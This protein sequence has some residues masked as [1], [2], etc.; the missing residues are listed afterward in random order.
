MNVDQVGVLTSCNGTS[1]LASLKFSDISHLNWRFSYITSREN[2]MRW[3]KEEFIAMK[4]V[5]TSLFALFFVFSL[6]VPAVHAEEGVPESDIQEDVAVQETESQPSAQVTAREKTEEN[7]MLLH[8]L[9]NEDKG[10]ASYIPT[11]TVSLYT[12][13]GDLIS[14]VEAGEQNYNEEEGRYELYFNFTEY[15]K[16]EKY[17]IL[18]NS[19]DDIVTGLA[20]QV[21]SLD[22]FAYGEAVLKKPNDYY[23]F[24]VD[25][26]EYYEDIDETK[27]VSALIPSKRFPMEAVLQT[28]KSKVG[29]YIVNEQ[30]QPLKNVPVQVRLEGGKGTLNLKTNDKGLAV[31]DSSKIPNT[32][33]VSVENKKAVGSNGYSAVVERPLTAL[34]SSQ[35]GILT[36]RLAFEDDISQEENAGFLNVTVST[37]GTS[38]L[39]SHWQNVDLNLTDT[40]GVTRTYSINA[41]GQKIYGL[42][43]GQYKVSVDSAYANAKLSVDSLTIKNGKGELALTLTP[44]YTLEVSKDGKAYDFSFVGVSGFESRNFTGNKSHVFAV[45]PGESYVIKDNVTGQLTT[46]AIDSNSLVTKVVLG[47]G[48]VFGGTIT[49]PHTGDVLMYLIV[50]ALVSTVLAFGFF[51]LYRRN[52]KILKS[53]TSLV[54]LLLVVTLMAQFFPPLADRAYADMGSGDAVDQ[55][56]GKFT[57]AGVIQ[58]SPTISVL[59]VGI[60]P[61][62]T[63]HEQE[64]VHLGKPID[65]KI[66]AGVAVEDLE[67]LLPIMPSDR[68]YYTDIIRKEDGAYVR[69]SPYKKDKDGYKVLR[70][71]SNSS[72]TNM[73]DIYKFTG[74][75]YKHMFYVAPNPESESILKRSN[76]TLLVFEDGKVKRLHGGT[77]GFDHGVSK[78]ASGFNLQDMILSTNGEAKTAISNEGLAYYLGSLIT[79]FGNIKVTL[80]VDDAFKGFVRDSLKYLSLSPEGRQLWKGEN[81]RSNQNIGDIMDRLFARNLSE[82]YLLNTLKKIS[83]NNKIV[84]TGVL[85]LITLEYLKNSNFWSEEFFTMYFNHLMKVGHEDYARKLRQ[86]HEEGDIQDLVF[87]AQV[88]PAFY[89][90]G[91]TSHYAFMPM[92][93]ATAW[94]RKGRSLENDDFNSI[95][96]AHEA[97]IMYKRN[98]DGTLERGGKL[99]SNVAKLYPTSTFVYNMRPGLAAALKP[100]SSNVPIPTGTDPKTGELL[101]TIDL[102]NSSE[103]DLGDNPFLGWGYTNL[104]DFKSRR[105][106]TKCGP[107]GVNQPKIYVKLEA[108][109][110]DS[111]GNVVDKFTHELEDWPSTGENVRYL[112]AINEFDDSHIISGGPT[113][114]HNDVVYRIQP[115]ADAEFQLLDDLDGENINKYPL[116]VSNVQTEHAKF[117]LLASNRER[118]EI[119]LGIDTPEARDLHTYLGGAD[120]PEGVDLGVIRYAIYGSQIPGDPV[121]LDDFIGSSDSSSNP[122][123]VENK[124]LGKK[125]KNGKPLY[126]DAKVVIPVT[127]REAGI[128]ESE[129][130]S[131]SLVVPEWRLTK[132]WDNLAVNGVRNAYFDVMFPAQTYRNARLSPSGYITFRLLNPDLTGIRWAESIAR[133]YGDTPTKYINVYSTEASFKL[134]GDLLAIK[135]NQQ[136]MDTKLASW[137]GVNNLVDGKIGSTDKGNPVTDTKVTKTHKFV[138]NVNSNVDPFSYTEDRWVS[139]GSF[140]DEFGCTPVY[141]WRPRTFTA[142]SKYTPVEYNVTV[143]FNRYKSKDNLTARTFA[144]EK[145]STNGFYWETKQENASLKVNPEVFML[146]DDRG[147]NTSFAFVAGD[148]LREIKPVTYNFARY[149]N[150]EVDPK[151]TGMSTATDTD[152]K[153]L[154]NRIAP[155]KEV[156]YKG[157]AVTTNFDVK[158]QLELRT[159]ALDI[160]NEALKN[161]WNPGTSYNTDR[162]NEEFLSRFATKDSSGN[163]QVT[164][165]AE[166]KLIIGTN[167]YGGVTDKLVAKENTGQRAVNTYV[168][169][170]RGG[171]LVGVNGNRNLNALH[172][173]LRD[174]LTRMKI[175]GDDN[176]FSAFEREGGEPLSEEFFATL[177]NQVRGTSDL[178]LNKG[179]Y[180][181][182]TT[183]LVVRE[184]INVFDLPHFLYV[185]KIPME[186][187]GLATPVDKTKF[188]S[189]GKAGHLKMTYRINDA[190]MVVDSSKGDFGIQRSIQYVVPNVSVLDTFG[191]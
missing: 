60:I 83:E 159:Y 2:R 68:C 87:F 13:K 161:A 38:S 120:D 69:F 9:Y 10:Y 135:D 7:G 58:T 111:N 174:A 165:D 4:R 5:F 42:P 166:G 123:E 103:P 27:L 61:A 19:K 112:N 33:A 146:H 144:E 133:L 22:F 114:V 80:V 36:F 167:E 188:F 163:W 183:I 67:D 28:D 145:Q 91:D 160:G 164:L 119:I 85:R 81:S 171:K 138:Y 66:P 6:L 116:L 175:L 14:T 45:T 47:A 40:D 46:V 115:N 149:I 186:V 150:V 121:N 1:G 53:K 29:L 134:A 92:H 63:L 43:D 62:F 107:D 157:S 78:H 49:N 170:V 139:V 55:T 125:D 95:S 102:P 130:G 31:V 178:A 100:R 97:R 89:V 180:N 184:Y 136:V 57:P 140:C 8:V 153:A 3:Y 151:L 106:I 41:E 23:T 190:Y 104:L 117:D 98:S 143:E 126:A 187:D 64:P 48:V 82:D 44:K 34:Q 17:N 59:Q 20:I 173:D 124:Y 158:G 88:V 15:K 162:I 122:A 74:E 127:V 37:D 52:Q 131:S 79:H 132:Y 99:E 185:D 50:L 51:A 30:G 105:C 176:V 24:T 12:E 54:S 84:G 109:V 182:D 96:D 26:W 189:D 65:V 108:S 75:Y 86:I 177:G 72:I 90:K 32:F 16:G 94:Y 147:G 113:I 56:G 18:L 101:S 148:K 179:W 169:E 21:D 181:E 152:A 73:E 93:D 76:T 70:L 110:L 129:S 154:A 142:S 191:N 71:C 118:W 172:P 35:T 137:L 128:R 155:G 77:L 11:F 168:L 141:D 39:S 25:S 156:V